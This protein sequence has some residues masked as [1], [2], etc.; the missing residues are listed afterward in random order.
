MLSSPAD[1]S[2]NQ[3][4]KTLTAQ[5]VWVLRVYFILLAYGLFLFFF[6]FLFLK[7]SHLVTLKHHAEALLCLKAK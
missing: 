7:G 3:V 6:L 2:L 4:D 1:P 5:P